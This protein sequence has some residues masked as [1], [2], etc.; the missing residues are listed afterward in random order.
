M[1]LPELADAIEQAF[2]DWGRDPRMN[3]PRAIMSDWRRLAVHQAAV[4]SQGHVGLKGHTRVSLH[5]GGTGGT[6]TF[7]KYHAAGILWDS[8]TGLIDAFVLDNVVAPPYW[9]AADMRTAATS[10]VGTRALARA[11]AHTV[12]ILGSGRQARSHLMAVAAIRDIR[13]AKVYS[14]NPEHRTRYAEQMIEELD[15]PIE[16]VDSPQEAVAGVDIV[17]VCTMPRKPAL[18]GEWLEPGQHITSCYGGQ[19]PTDGRGHPTE[20]SGRD[21]DDAVLT[22]SDVIVINSRQQ[23]Q[24]DFQGDM[25]EPIERGLLTWDR[26]HELSE[27]LLGQIEGR[28]SDEQI[29]LYKNNGAPAFADVVTISMV[30][31]KARQLGIGTEI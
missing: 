14:P 21:L 7:G 27:L 26:V 1:S 2:R 8:D 13:S 17:L 10:T 22:R 16:P 23:A 29:T 28:T 12:G 24:D 3:M 11:N 5:E 19:T 18:L 15:I 25:L 31:K 4:P 30:A 20:P 6:Y 9:G